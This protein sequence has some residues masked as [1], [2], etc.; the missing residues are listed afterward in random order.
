MGS[1]ELEIARDPTRLGAV[2]GTG[3]LDSPP[4]EAF[5]RVTRGA[6][7]TLGTR[8]S[9]VTLLDEDRQFFK[10]S[11]GLP[12]PWASHGQTPLSHSYCK[13][14]VAD[15]S[16]FAVENARRHP[17]V[18]DNPAIEDLGVIAYLGVPLRDPSGELVGS[19][20]VFDAEPRRWETGEVE[21][22]EVFGTA[23]EAEIW[24]S[25]AERERE[26][27]PYMPYRRLVE[28]LPIGLLVHRAGE[29]L[30][31]NR[32]ALKLMGV[33]A[34]DHVKGASMLEF[35]AP[36]DRE[37]V[38]EQ[39]RKVQ[40][41]REEIELQR[42]GLAAADGVTRTVEAMAVPV[43]MWGEPVVQV[44]IRD[45]TELQ[46]TETKFSHLFQLSPVATTLSTLEGGY[47]E[48]VNTA[49]EELVG[50]DREELIGRSA[51]DLDLW[52]D[53]AERRRFIDG[54]RE[55]GTVR[56]M[57]SQIRN[58]T[59]AIRE[60][61]LFGERVELGG[62]EYLISISYDITEQK[63]LERELERQALHDMLTGLPNRALFE[64]RLEHA[65]EQMPRRADELAVF[66]L[67]LD[68]FKV[69]NDTLGH[70]AGDQLLQQVADRLSSSVREGDTV[71][72]LGGDEFAVLLEA[73]DRREARTVAD[74]VVEV[75]TSA[76]TVLETDVHVD[77]SIGIGMSS[78]ELTDS[79]DLIRFSN[80]AMYHAKDVAGTA[81][82][83]FDPDRDARATG[84]LHRENELRRAL[85]A[86]EFEVHYQPLVAL[87]TGEI[88][89]AEALVRWRHPE[90]GLVSPGE[91][92]GLAEETGMILPLGKWVL[93]AAGRAAAAWMNGKPEGGLTLS[94]NMSPRQ[95]Q[96]PRLVE[97]LESLLEDT[98]FPPGSLTL[99]IT[100][101][102]AM[103]ATARV[104]QLRELGV[105]LAVDDFGTG[106]SSLEYLRQLNVD[107][108]KVDRAFIE[109]LTENPTDQAMVRAILLVADAMDLAVV[110]EGIETELQLRCLRDLGCQIGQGYYF[111]RPVPEDAF[112][113]IL[114]TPSV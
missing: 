58:A 57:E 108:L 66:Y 40:E 90:R 96:D 53:P 46:R 20:A 69:V 28:D 32:L 49:F 99:E 43:E 52:T 5:D 42:Y 102:V 89:G 35:V 50:Y 79:G 109:D 106:Y 10:S 80:V 82:V 68:R 24:R 112:R 37:R 71:A 22:M 3:L 76:F 70:G 17:R 15:G 36:E 105:R 31:A 59:G 47:L 26:A 29:V 38:V 33:D 92:I 56:R 65:F 14:V 72:R 13:F 63:R 54:I 83:F 84:R 81:Y 73:K 25:A 55:R 78:E 45:V 39:V 67:D 100:E 86:E 1:R 111:S 51:L 60:V 87:S 8:G 95:F 11:H 98:A 77:A 114:Q 21:L 91:F 41:E 23:V 104:E 97:D 6:A 75:F 48:E 9:L 64:D 2:R 19:F 61:L 4:E 85:E 113:K 101:G 7:R 103:Q 62:E 88:L 16:A 18:R 93:A 110:A 12:E 107:A 27:G 30:W 44:A 74:R 34:L 94:V